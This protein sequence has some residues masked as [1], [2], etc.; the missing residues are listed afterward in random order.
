MKRK[1][2]T[3]AAFSLG[4]PLGIGGCINDLL[5]IVAPLIR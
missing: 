1:Y 3:L 2:A 5:F 4:F